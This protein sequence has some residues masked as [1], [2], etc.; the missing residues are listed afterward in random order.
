MGWPFLYIFYHLVN[1]KYFSELFYK[2]IIIKI[3]LNFYI[4]FYVIYIR[5]L[6]QVK[7]V[8]MRVVNFEMINSEPRPSL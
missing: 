1:H 3:F 8:D 7:N 2:Q 4:T 5:F 6:P